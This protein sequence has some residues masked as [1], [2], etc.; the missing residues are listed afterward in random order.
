MGSIDFRK[1]FI[2]VLKGPYGSCIEQG[3][4]TLEIEIVLRLVG[5]DGAELA[6]G[7]IH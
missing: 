4:K 3:K 2:F 5:S 6:V 7:I 1:G